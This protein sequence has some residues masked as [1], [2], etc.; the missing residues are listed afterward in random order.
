MWRH[1]KHLEVEIFYMLRNFKC[2]IFLDVR[3]FVW[4]YELLALTCQVIRWYV[5]H[6]FVVISFFDGIFTV[7]LQNPFYCNSWCLLRDLFCRNLRTFCVET[8]YVQDFVR[9]EKMTNIMYGANSWPNSTTNTSSAISWP[10][11]QPIQ[12]ASPGGQNRN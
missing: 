8:N 12:V 1:F 6:C 2:E 7:L 11:W 3:K 5:S 10:H 4:F 9:G